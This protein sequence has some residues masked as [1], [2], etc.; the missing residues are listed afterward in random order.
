ML[1]L[2]DKSECVLYSSNSRFNN[3][4]LLSF[5]N[6]VSI[7]PSKEVSEKGN[8]SGGIHYIMYR[9]KRNKRNY[10]NITEK[11][12]QGEKASKGESSV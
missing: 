2:N 11:R 12:K 1:V 10:K 9:N 6:C 3:K 7:W 5:S 4:Y 8:K